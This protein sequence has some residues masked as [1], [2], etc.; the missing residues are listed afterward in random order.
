MRRR[1]RTIVTTLNNNKA[2]D[3][4]AYDLEKSDYFADH[5]VIATALADK[6][7]LSLLEK[8]KDKLKPKGEE[9][10]HVDDTSGWVVVD[11]GDIL[12]HI[13]TEEYRKRFNLEEFMEHMEKKAKERNK[14][15]LNPLDSD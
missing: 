2:E 6:H 3:V 7:A 12:V 8:L 9:F 13:M 15:N 14:P 5:V 4:V 11:M 10:Q 1:V